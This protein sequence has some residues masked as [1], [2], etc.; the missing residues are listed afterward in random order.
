MEPVIDFGKLQEKLDSAK[1][2]D[3]LIGKNGVFVELF[4]HTIQKMLEAEATEHLGYPRGCRVLK[5]G[6]N[7]RNGNSTK[8]VR[9]SFGDMEIDIPRDRDG[10]FEPQLLPKYTK[11]T[12]ELED[13]IISMYA[14]GMS[15]GELNEHLADMYGVTVSDTLISQITDK[16]WPDV[17]A[18][19][20]RVLEVTYPI[21]FIDAIHYKVRD[22]GQVKSRAA[23]IALGYNLE[24]QKDVLGI[25]IGENESSKFW[26]SVLAELKNRGVKNILIVSCDNLTGL[27]DAIKICFPNAVIQKCIVHQIRNSL[28]YVAWKNQKEFI[29]DLKPVY[30]ASTIA[31]AE[32]NLLELEKKWGN[33]YPIVFKSWHDN[34][35]ELSAFFQFTSGIRKLIYTTNPIESFNRQLRKVTKSKSVFP[36]NKS[37]LKM[38]FL[39]TNNITK[40][41]DKSRMDWH[42][43]I[44]ELSIHFGDVI[45]INF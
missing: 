40:R 6:T 26:L 43:T 32:T 24:G 21:V 42:Q 13:K 34:W 35:A 27:S 30:Q 14:R 4:Q 8:K 16:I 1:T 12:S 18:W 10:S 7:K 28:K 22:E 39:A 11:N 23:Y 37:L 33:K 20:Q 19:T 2:M 17:E 15:V 45:N 44:A 29:K 31:L 25:W 41:W 36:S 38:L 5:Q 9:S 3:D